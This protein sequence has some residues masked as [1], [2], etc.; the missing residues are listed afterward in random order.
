MVDD[1]PLGQM[2]SRTAHRDV[3]V[4]VF[5]H[6]GA[7]ARNQGDYE[8]AVALSSKALT[9]SQGCG[10]RW[11]SAWSLHLLGLVEFAALSMY[12]QSP[13]PFRGYARFGRTTVASL[14]GRRLGTAPVLLSLTVTQAVN[15]G[16]SAT[17]QSGELRPQ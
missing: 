10:A 9:L 15:P 11:D 17:R 7:V 8:R 3:V 16:A 12:V 1:V 13:G 14:T 2:T 4:E 6:L 5:N